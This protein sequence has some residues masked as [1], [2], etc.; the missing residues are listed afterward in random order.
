MEGFHH[1]F[2]TFVP[3]V[4]GIIELLG[5][6]II[7]LSVLKSFGKLIFVEKFNF[8]LAEKDLVL[9]SG[10]S[11]A[12]EFFLAAEV[13]KTLIADSTDKLI[14]LGALV[15]IRIVI[16]L[17]IHWEMKQKVAHEILEEHNN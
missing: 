9:N 14:Q 3:P 7:I 8:I 5:L 16:T 6:F 11:T 4:A 13:L 10:L 17:I 2:V 15:I 12:L 1:I